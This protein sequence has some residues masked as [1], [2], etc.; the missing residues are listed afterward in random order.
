[1]FMAILPRAA[2]LRSGTIKLKMPVDTNSGCS[3]ESKSFGDIPSAEAS[4]F[5]LIFAGLKM[6]SF[7]VMVTRCGR[8]SLK[9]ISTGKTPAP[10]S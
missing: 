9:R 5:L 10:V 7:C 2:R 4:F 6:A 1:M 3:F 8:P